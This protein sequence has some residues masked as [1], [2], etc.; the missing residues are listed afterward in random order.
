MTKARLAFGYVFAALLWFTHVAFIPATVLL[1]VTGNWKF[2]P[3]LFLY[4]FFVRPALYEVPH[5][6]F[7]ANSEDYRIMFAMRKLTKR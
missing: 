6:I 4:H 1:A 7:M 3:S 5:A 2:I